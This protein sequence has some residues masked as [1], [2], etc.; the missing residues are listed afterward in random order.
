M[1][2]SLVVGF[3]ITVV[4]SFEVVVISQV[5]GCIITVVPLFEVV[6]ISSW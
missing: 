5:C 4:P 1:V 6:V 3:I 2:K